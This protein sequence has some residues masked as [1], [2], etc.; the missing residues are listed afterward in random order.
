[1]AHRHARTAARA[2]LA[3]LGAL[4][5]AAAPSAVAAE[6]APTAGPVP[7][8]AQTLG[9]DRPSAHL[10]QAL[11]RDLELTS[12]QAS[13]RLVNEAEAGTRA[14]VLRASLGDR[15]A[16]AWVRGATS[17]ELTVATTDAADVPAI[18]EQGARAAVVGRSLGDR[19]AG[20]DTLVGAA[21]GRGAPDT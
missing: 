2:A 16:G 13:E 11:G 8:A 5:L 19:T 18:Q 4:A 10:L 20:P 6:P 12:A 17:G 1:M 14:G 9:A 3:A 21:A 15:F 7:G